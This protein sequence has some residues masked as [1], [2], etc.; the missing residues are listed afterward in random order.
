M[1]NRTKS[2]SDIKKLNAIRDFTLKIIKIQDRLIKKGRY[3]KRF[4]Y[5]YSIDVLA[6]LSFACKSYE[7]KNQVIFVNIGQ[8][9]HLNKYAP[10]DRIL[11]SCFSPGNFMSCLAL[12]LL[13]SYRSHCILIYIYSDVISLSQLFADILFDWIE[14]RQTRRNLRLHIIIIA[15]YTHSTICP[16][17]AGTADETTVHSWLYRMET[18]KMLALT[19]ST[20]REIAWQL[21]VDS[22]VV[23]RSP[24]DGM[25]T[26]F[27]TSPSIFPFVVFSFFVSIP[28]RWL[29][30]DHAHN[31]LNILKAQSKAATHQTFSFC[32]DQKMDVWHCVCY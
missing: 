31:S 32:A 3:S 17:F 14:R 8:K 4:T 18:Y 21:A 28:F 26:A 19:G 1:L 6:T 20:K 22:S 13:L 9:F 29:Y 10:I 12:L 25:H 15:D 5:S 11:E 24:F 27:S 7:L 30:C 16:P 23:I 2:I